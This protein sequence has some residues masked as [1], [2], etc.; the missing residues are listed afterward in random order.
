MHKKMNVLHSDSLFFI[1][2]LRT[3]TVTWNRFPIF[4]NL[5]MDSTQS[6]WWR[7]LY[8]FE[9]RQ[10]VVWII[11]NE[12]SRAQVADSSKACSKL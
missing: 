1:L 6:S 5:L 4:T 8:L 12:E 2:G 3:R 7:L 11:A 9:Y 10:V